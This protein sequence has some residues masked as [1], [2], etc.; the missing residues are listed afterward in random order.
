MIQ[1]QNLPQKFNYLL[2][3]KKLHIMK[4]KLIVFCSL[5]LVALTMQS[6]FTKALSDAKK[7]LEEEEEI[8]SGDIFQISSAT[9]EYSNGIVFAFKEYGRYQYIEEEDEITII[10]PKKRY[11]LDKRY[12]SYTAIETD[13]DESGYY[14]EFVFLEEAWKVAN[15]WDQYDE[16]SNVS[17]KKVT[18]CGK[19]CTIYVNEDGDAEGG[20]K[21]IILYKNTYD[22]EVKATS[23]KESADKSLFEVPADYKED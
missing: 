1:K 22:G 18:I 10:T 7:I 5:M 19:S 6:C 4:K 23:L 20:W 8:V 9:V 16:E 11:E 21:R 2:T 12:K 17:S 15:Y 13:L 14:S 3:P